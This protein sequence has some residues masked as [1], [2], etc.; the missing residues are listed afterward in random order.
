MDEYGTGVHAAKHS[1]LYEKVMESAELATH[2][3][4]YWQF[5]LPSS[6]SLLNYFHYVSK[7]HRHFF[8]YLGALYFTEA[9]LAHANSNQSRVLRTVFGNKIDTL[10]FDEHAH[11]DRH[12]GRMALEEVI[13]PIVKRVGESVL[14]DIVRGFEEFCLLQNIADDDLVRQIKWCDY[15]GTGNAIVASPPCDGRALQDHEEERG[16]LSVTHIHDRSEIIFVKK[17]ELDII[18]G[19]GEPV[20]LRPGQGLIIPAGRLHGS[21]VVSDS[22]LYSIFPLDS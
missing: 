12:H 7:S 2:P 3:H 19:I 10:Y 15:L 8:R 11:I 9:T 14:P 18:T 13:E 1:S 17:G 6:L 22:C 20:H 21:R 4:H 5:F 16:L